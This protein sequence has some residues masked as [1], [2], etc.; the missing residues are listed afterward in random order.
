MRQYTTEE[1]KELKNMKIDTVKIKLLKGQM[2][3]GELAEKANLSK[4]GLYL[5]LKKGRCKPETVLR[6]AEALDVEP[7]EI[8]LNE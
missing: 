7:T 4:N 5:I 2:Q 6:I 3:Q 1:I 8:I